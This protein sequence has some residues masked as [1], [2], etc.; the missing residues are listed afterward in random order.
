MARKRKPG[1]PKGSKNKPG[2]KAGRPRKL[3]SALR[4]MRSIDESEFIM[5]RRGR[6]RPKG[7]KNKP[8]ISMSGGTMA[9]QRVIIVGRIKMK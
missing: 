6:G 2:H 7:S 4:R 3:S 9:G 1:R 5:E 8:K